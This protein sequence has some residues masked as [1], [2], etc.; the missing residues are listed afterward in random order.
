MTRFGEISPLWQLFESLF[1]IWQI[2]KLILT[3]IDVIGQIFVAANSTI[4]QPS[5]VDV[6]NFFGGKSRFPQNL[7]I[8][9]SSLQCLNL[10]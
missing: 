3:K 8:E 5:V 2:I 10:H 9:I 7:E 4:M 1:T 6:K